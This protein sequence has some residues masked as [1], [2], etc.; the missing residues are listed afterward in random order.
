MK[1][2]AEGTLYLDERVR[3]LTDGK[4]AY[5]KK[6]LSD[7]N[8][9]RDHVPSKSLLHK[10]YP[11]NLPVVGACTDCNNGFSGDEEYLVAFLGCVLAGSTDPQDMSDPRARRIL[12][13]NP[14]LR[15]RIESAR[16]SPPSSDEP[17]YWRPEQERVRNV[18]VKNARGHLLFECSEW[19][20][21]DPTYV[22]STALDLL[23][24]EH[25]KVFEIESS[26]PPLP[27]IGSRMFVRSWTGELENG[28]NIAQEGSYRFAVDIHDSGTLEVRIVIAEYFAAGVVWHEE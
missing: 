25:R 21:D 4:C 11:E 18:L 3:A 9:T 2:I 16:V 22:F 15:A 10:P 8:C 17:P 14:R 24:Q 28:W 13:R 7:E 19:R 20:I 6:S 1:Q 26:D 5:C 23:P 12:E 27:E